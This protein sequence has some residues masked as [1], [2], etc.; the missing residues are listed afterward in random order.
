MTDIA[1][2]PYLIK[3]GG[4]MDRPNGA[5]QFVNNEST[6]QPRPLACLFLRMLPKVYPFNR[7]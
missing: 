5:G 2:L 6:V 3:P 7:L 4:S 1:L